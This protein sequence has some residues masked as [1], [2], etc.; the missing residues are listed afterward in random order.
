MLFPRNEWPDDTHKVRL[1]VLDTGVDSTH[2]FMTD[3]KGR[4]KVHEF[5]DFTSS[6][7]PNCRAIDTC[8]HGTHVAGVILQLAPYIELYVARVFENSSHRDDG[9][10]SAADRVATV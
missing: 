10:A 4:P 9:T 3:I 7:A 8:G 6:S 5:K 1:A 2:E